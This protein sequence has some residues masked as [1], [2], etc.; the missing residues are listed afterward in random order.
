M[1]DGFAC[2]VCRSGRAAEPYLK[3]PDR[4]GVTHDLVRCC[5]CGA[6][7]VWPPPTEAFLADFYAS[8]Y[9]GRVKRGIIVGSEDFAAANVAVIRDGAVKLDAVERLT[10][11]GPGGD[12]LD[13][14]CGFGLF[15]YAAQARG[16]RAVG[17]DL[18][19][20]ALCVGRDTMA[21]DLRELPIEAIRSQP[22]S[23]DMITAWQG[24]EHVRAPRSSVDA[25][26]VALRP[27]G[28]FAG[29]VPNIGGVFAK[30]TGKRWYLLVPPEHLNYFDESSLRRMLHECGFSR[31]FV[32]TIPIYASP[33]FS[34]GLRAAVMRFGGRAR[35]PLVR[36]ACGVT[37]RCLTLLKRHGVYRVLNAVIIK[38]R[39]GGNSLFFVAVKPD[40]VDCAHGACDTA[41]EA[42]R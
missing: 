35:A 14:G 5:S 32:G 20:D 1:I 36:R 4:S 38:T 26:A 29:A 37:Q 12:L 18:D 9:D 16:Y 3:V 2:T 42:A 31:C 11:R 40:P 24:M 8:G 7:V 23:Y 34:F 17:I 21:L 27:G 28:V 10:G 30:L 15:V 39:L 25:V 19:A 41:Q 6:V 33:Y 13:I 22:A